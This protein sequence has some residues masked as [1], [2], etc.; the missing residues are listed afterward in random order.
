M[1][2]KSKA[3]VNLILLAVTLFI[4]M[5]GAFGLI[6]DLSQK[7][8]SDRYPTLITPA[9]STFSIWSMIYAMLIIAVVV[10]VIKQKDV[11]YSKAMD[12][13][14]RLFW[15]TCVL[16]MVWI[17][18]FS[19]EWIGVSSIFI[20]ALLI[21]LVV[22]VKR[23][24]SIDASRRWLLPTAFGLYSGWLLIATVVNIA[25]WL[26]KIEWGRLGLAAEGWSVATLVIALGLTLFVV[27]NIKN[28]VFPVPIAWAYFG[29]YNSLAA[30]QSYDMLK[31]TAL[32]GV[33]L[34]AGLALV[35]F[36]RNGY[37]V[38]PGL[39]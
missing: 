35:Q 13:I 15:L 26:V 17:I 16:N 37:R 7:E 23:I 18:S 20:F 31:W 32:V 9:P 14:S 39:Q 21:G 38:M 1:K 34:L 19:Y 5:M 33:V 29:I 10:M 27:M 11:Y 6:N 4:N 3:L 8:I 24:G 36:F 25:A 30:G 28:A 12:R 22:I 2:R